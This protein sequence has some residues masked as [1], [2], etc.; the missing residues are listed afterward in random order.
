MC[1]RHLL[2]GA[3]EKMFSNFSYW[4]RL[5]R[6]IFYSIFFVFMVVNTACV[7]ASHQYEAALSNLRNA[8]LNMSV[9][10]SQ[11]TQTPGSTLTPTPTPTSVTRTT[12][13]GAVFTLDTD[14]PV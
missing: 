9:A 14:S 1:S 12:T 3:R 13:T 7:N 6:N 4:N 2:I 5:R 11:G 10:N 8:S